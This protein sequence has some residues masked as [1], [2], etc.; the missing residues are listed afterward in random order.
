MSECKDDTKFVKVGVEGAKLVGDVRGV[1]TGED[2]TEDT[3]DVMTS[4]GTDVDKQCSTGE[5]EGSLDGD[6]FLADSIA[7]PGL[8][9]V[10][11][12]D[13]AAYSNDLSHFGDNVPHSGSCATLS[14]PDAGDSVGDRVDSACNAGCFEGVSGIATKVKD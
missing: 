10:N 12:V 2:S 13:G 7:V 14:A 4:G 1:D 3:E 5:T 11:F 6:L 8:G 9:A